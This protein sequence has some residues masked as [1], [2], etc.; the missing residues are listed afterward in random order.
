MKKLIKII[1]N[2]S[3]VFYLI[4]L[5]VLLFL[6]SRGFIWSGLTMIE[7]IKN[8]SNFV[9]FKTISTYI[10]AFFDGSMNIEI[11][12]KNLF[13]NLLM[14]LPAG[15]YLP[16]YIRKINKISVFII[17]MSIVLVVIEVVQVVA[18][19][20]SFDIDDYIL[21]M[22][23]ALIGFGIWKTEFVKKLLR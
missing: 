8:S 11:P 4:A 22:L 13:G 10:K 3:F 17:A 5:A 12:I 14:F 7:Y 19:R 18:R 16:Y 6:G 20:G 2:I 1:L 21:N 9:P 23:G 15:I